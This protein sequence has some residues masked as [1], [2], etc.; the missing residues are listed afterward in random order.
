MYLCN[1]HRSHSG[2]FHILSVLSQ[3]FDHGSVCKII[4]VLADDVSIEEHADLIPERVGQEVDDAYLSV[5]F[6]RR[7]ILNFTLTLHLFRSR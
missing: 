5:T 6:N 7:T 1:N 3:E 4:G 2:I